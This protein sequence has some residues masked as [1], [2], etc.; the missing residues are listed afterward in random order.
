MFVFSNY[1]LSVAN[2]LLLALSVDRLVAVWRPHIYRVK[3]KPAKAR[4]IVVAIACFSFLT[5]APLMAGFEVEGGS[6][7]VGKHASGPIVSHAFIEWYARFVSAFLKL[8][9]PGITH[10]V[11]DSLI[12][13]RV[14]CDRSIK[15]LFFSSFPTKFDGVLGGSCTKGS[16]A[17]F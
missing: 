11:L 9:F 4:P 14:R 6:C 8:T 15:L 16:G 2:Y 12:V 10:V 13:Y 5:C 7:F 3:G 1:F 17:L